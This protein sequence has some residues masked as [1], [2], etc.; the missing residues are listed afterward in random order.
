L[1]EYVIAGAAGVVGT[2]VASCVLV[3]RKE[4]RT[5]TETTGAHRRPRGCPPDPVLRLALETV[6]AQGYGLDQN[7][8]ND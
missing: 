3:S 4:D 5:S 1:L 8:E 2:G 6:G 7:H